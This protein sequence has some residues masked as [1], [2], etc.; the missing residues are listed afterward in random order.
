[1]AKDMADTGKLRQQ[2]KRIGHLVLQV[3]GLDPMLYLNASGLAAA[4][5]VIPRML[6]SVPVVRVPL[7]QRWCLAI[8]VK[9]FSARST[10]IQRPVSDSSEHEQDS[11]S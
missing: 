2:R 4:L 8:N 5:R 10:R 1:M 9:G 11:E 3:H 7:L 6:M